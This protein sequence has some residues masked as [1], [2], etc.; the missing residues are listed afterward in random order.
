MQ[1]LDFGGGGVTFA[2]SVATGRLH[3]LLWMFSNKL[4]CTHCIITLFKKNEGMK[5][6]EMWREV[7]RM[8]MIKIYGTDVIP[9]KNK[10]ML[11]V[12]D[13]GFISVGTVLL[14]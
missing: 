8:G 2:V 4:H 9:S 12:Q 14:V 5:L 13:M 6:G 3:R 11:I 1:L 10:N 7:A